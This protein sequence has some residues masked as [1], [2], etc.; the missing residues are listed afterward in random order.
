M[1]CNLSTPDVDHSHD[2]LVYWLFPACFFLSALVNARTAAD[3]IKRPQYTFSTHPARPMQTNVNKVHVSMKTLC[4]A[5]SLY[6]QM[7]DVPAAAVRDCKRLQLA[8]C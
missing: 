4:I 1:P 8:D 5:Q 2:N 7:H 6:Q 3:T